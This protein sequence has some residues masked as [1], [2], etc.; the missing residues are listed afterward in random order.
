MLS[1][2]RLSSLHGGFGP[3]R[4]PAQ[5]STWGSEWA[6]ELVGVGAR[7]GNPSLQFFLE[8]H[9]VS[10]VVMSVLCQQEL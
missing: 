2:P 6:S 4:S 5:T 3:T 9:K 10:E 1:L 8:K 7:M